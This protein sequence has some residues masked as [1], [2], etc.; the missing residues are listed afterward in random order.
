MLLERFGSRSVEGGAG[1]EARR[2]RSRFASRESRFETDA[3]PER[4]GSWPAQEWKPALPTRARI[5]E[6]RFGCNGLHGRDSPKIAGGRHRAQ[7]QLG[8]QTEAA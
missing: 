7:A 2:G 1:A 6:R 5:K 4:P 3:V 8:R